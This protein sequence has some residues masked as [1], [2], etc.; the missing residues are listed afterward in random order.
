MKN[1]LVSLELKPSGLGHLVL[2]RPD[3]LNAF[4]KQMMADFMSCLDE[5][6]ENIAQNRLRML[7]LS[8]S[9]PK[10]FCVGADLTE[11]LQMSKEEVSLVLDQQNEIMNGVAAL[12]VPTV[13]VLEGAAFGGGL[14]LALAA[15]IRIA[16]PDAQLG[17][18]ETRL[19]IIPGAGG[20]QRL[21]R[22]LGASRAKELIFRGARLSGLEAEKISLVNKCDAKPRVLAEQWAQEILDAAPLAIRA[23]KRAIE[24]GAE[25]GLNEALRWERQCYEI[26][27]ESQDRVEGL[28]AFSEKRKPRFEG[29]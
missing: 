27:L 5:L 21:S 7:I 29:K 13:A 8:S 19:G 10:A 12:V 28:K 1:T 3:K 26:T 9:T 23:A 2:N 14:E 17:L 4:S 22:L 20:T 16:A 25:L 18:S 15:D 6:R 24:E 11:R